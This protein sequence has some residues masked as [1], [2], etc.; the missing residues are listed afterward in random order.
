MRAACARELGGVLTLTAASAGTHVLAWFAGGT[1]RDRVSAAYAPRVAQAA[2]AEG[3][4]VFPISRYCLEPPRRDGFVLGF[5][6][7][8][9]RQIA[10]GAAR[11]ARVI[12]RL[13]SSG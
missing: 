12:E 13:R 3:L 5:G 10:T 2:A 1:R 7:V 8:S 9:P 6:A 4:V 11:L